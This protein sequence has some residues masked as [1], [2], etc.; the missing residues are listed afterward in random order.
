[1]H[2]RLWPPPYLSALISLGRYLGIGKELSNVRKQVAQASEWRGTVRRS[3]R[4]GEYLQSELPHCRDAPEF[5]RLFDHS[6]ERS[7]L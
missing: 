2:Y 5:W 1:M 7:V 3:H 6:A 4:L